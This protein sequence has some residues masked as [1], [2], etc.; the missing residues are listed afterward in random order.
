MTDMFSCQ[1]F[2]LLW[3]AISRV[4]QQKTHWLWQLLICIAFSYINTTVDNNYTLILSSEQPSVQTVG[5]MGTLPLRLQS[6]LSEQN[7]LVRNL[8]F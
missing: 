7:K 6:H 8:V 3:L 2:L 1:E 5:G 4:I